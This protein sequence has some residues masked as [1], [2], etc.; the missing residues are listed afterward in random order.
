VVGL[1][2][3]RRFAIAAAMNAGAGGLTDKQ[4]ELQDTITDSALNNNKCRG[5]IGEPGTPGKLDVSFTT[6]PYGGRYT[7]A[8]CGAVWIEDMAGNYIP[9]PA[10]WRR[11]RIRPIYFYEAVRCK[12]DEPD[13]ITSATLEEHRPHS[14]TWDGKDLMDKVVP[15]GMYVL[16]IEVTEDEADAGERA[17][18][19]FTKGATPLTVMP[20][21]T[22]SVK[23]LK[24][25]YTPSPA[26]PVDPSTGG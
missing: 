3:E 12:A 2:E 14:V 7:P 25:V 9:A 21:D 4:K 1:T 22:V 5:A 10:V 11:I 23:G 15:D 24:L 6:A 13:A 19:P 16:N 26:T 8:N 17:Q 20:P 18:Y